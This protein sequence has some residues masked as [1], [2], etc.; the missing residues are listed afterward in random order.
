MTQEEKDKM[1]KHYTRMYVSRFKKVAEKA[2]RDGLE[3]AI[4]YYKEKCQG[5]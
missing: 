3:D 1:V 4:K 2:Y 5:L